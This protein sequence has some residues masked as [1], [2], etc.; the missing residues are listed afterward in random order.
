MILGR[1]LG[2]V[3]R[4][5]CSPDRS[6]VNRPVTLSPAPNFDPKFD[7]RRVAQSQP[8]GLDDRGARQ[9]LGKVS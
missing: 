2:A 8:G 7:R 5:A 4:H 9:P 3:I 1:T 6:A